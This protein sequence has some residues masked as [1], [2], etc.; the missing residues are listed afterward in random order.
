MIQ[1]SVSVG[2]LLDK[3]SILTIKSFKILDKDKA[4]LVR[5]ELR[6]LSKLAE[7]YLADH[8]IEDQYTDL[9]SVNINLWEIEDNIRAFE[10]ANK[11]DDDFI[12]LARLVYEQNDIRSEIKAKINRLTNSSLQEVKHYTEYK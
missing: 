1:I 2:E 8:T 12:Q 11:F 5:Q 4:R 9:L 7:S 3:L 6:L 10:K